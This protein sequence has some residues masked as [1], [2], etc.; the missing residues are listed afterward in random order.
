MSASPAKLA[1]S[2]GLTKVLADTPVRTGWLE[3]GAALTRLRGPEA[4]LE[5]GAHPRE[6]LALFL[7]GQVTREDAG[8]MAGLRWTF[9]L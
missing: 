1:V 7:R 3:A 5:A 9:D 4:W 2:E 6:D 8:V